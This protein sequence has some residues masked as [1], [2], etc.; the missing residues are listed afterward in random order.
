MTLLPSRPGAG[1]LQ[2]SGDR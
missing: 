1:S 2:R